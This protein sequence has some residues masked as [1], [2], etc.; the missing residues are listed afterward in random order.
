MKEM[1][2]VDHLTE[3]R[4]RLMYSVGFI[5]VAFFVCYHF[6]EHIQN[7]LLA[8]LRGALDSEGKI[9]FAGLLD[10][11]LAQ[12]QLCFW[13]AIILSSPF[14]F[15][16][17]WLFVKPGLYSKEVKLI[18]PFVLLGFIL[19]WLGISFGYFIVFP[20]TFE[21]LLSF[22]VGG[23]EAYMNM[24][25]YLILSSKILVF[26]GFVFQLPNIL[27]VLGFMGIINSKV[28]IKYQKYVV[29]GFAVL[30]AILTPPD[31]ITM[32]ALWVPLV[33]LYLFGVL[34][35]YLLVDPFQRN[36]NLEETN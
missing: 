34:L 26:L 28:L 10:K 7:I 9:V 17:V 4:K 15:Y 12:F 25:D 27:L 13:S 29:V 6:G 8:P 33:G 2:L 30:S 16:Q 3:L 1:S 22:G 21:T 18:R 35:V 31:P 14:W 23:V 20:Y 36:N 11:V 19:F 24:K 32:M 5:F